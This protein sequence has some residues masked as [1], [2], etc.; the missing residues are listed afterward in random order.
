MINRKFF[1]ITIKKQA[2]T[3]IVKQKQ[4]EGFEA[5]FNYWETD[6]NNT[7]LR[8][9]AYMLATAWHETAFTMQPVE[10]YGKGKGYKYGVPDSETGLIY[11]GRGYVQLTWKKNYETFQRILNI[12][13]VAQPHRACE[14]QVAAIIMFE[15]MKRG[16]F[17]GKKLSDYINGTHKCDFVNARRIINGTDKAE[18]IASYAQKFLLALSTI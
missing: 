3:S 18:L 1:F 7:D 2:L 17:T 5:I 8:H 14:P 16:L 11:Y 15:G 10:E 9:L 6:L 4:L 12:P 13:L